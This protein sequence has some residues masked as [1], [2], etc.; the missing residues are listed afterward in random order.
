[1]PVR[2]FISSS[3][4]GKVKRI[5]PV[6]LIFSP[7][8]NT[9]SSRGSLSAATISDPDFNPDTCTIR[10]NGAGAE[11]PNGDSSLTSSGGFHGFELMVQNSTT[12]LMIS[13]TTPISNLT[14]NILV[15]EYESTA[16]SSP[17]QHGY[18]DSQNLS[19]TT[20]RE[21]LVTIDTAIQNP[22]KSIAIDAKWNGTNAGGG[23]ILGRTLYPEPI[24]ST[25]IKFKYVSTSGT[26]YAFRA[27]QVVPF[28]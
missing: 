21:E 1:M 26:S 11:M 2:N 10:I 6:A 14:V 8:T 5:T 16:L 25:T 7:V 24:D 19:G 4:A 9:V 12:I 27:W 23:T 18:G 28:K 17:V 15:T 22:N 13:H 20:V 3:G